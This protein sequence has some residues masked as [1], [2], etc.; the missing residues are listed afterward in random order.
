LFGLSQ[1]RAAAHCLSMMAAFGRHRGSGVAALLTDTGAEA[2]GV[3]L[4]YSEKKAPEIVT[5]WWRKGG[6]RVALKG[7]NGPAADCLPNVLPNICCATQSAAQNTADAARFRPFYA[8][9]YDLS[10]YFSVCPTPSCRL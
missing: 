9:E 7:P 6:K 10:P 4:D 3:Q 1:D 8:V 5:S 2:N